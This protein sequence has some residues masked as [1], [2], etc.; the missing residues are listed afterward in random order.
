[1][2]ALAKSP[3]DRYQQCTEMAADLERARRATDSATRRT[4]Q[5]ALDRYR[6]T[7]S[8]IE[9][10]RALAR[11]LQTAGGDA[12]AEAALARL[13][14]RFPAFAT[15]SPTGPVDDKDRIAANEALE[16]IQVRYNAEVAELVAMREGIAEAPKRTPEADAED[17]ASWKDRAAALWRN[18]QT[19]R[20]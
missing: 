9:E 14:A 2:K 3:A 4:V 20:E 5:A 7:V 19:P 18:L 12:A 16:E 10:R 11:A 15:A 6:Q 8:I 13:A 1:M 17:A